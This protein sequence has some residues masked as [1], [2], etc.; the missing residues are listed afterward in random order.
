MG[1]A[2]KRQL[3]GLLIV[4]H[5]GVGAC[6]SV[7]RTPGARAVYV[8]NLS[9]EVLGPLIAYAKTEADCRTLHTVVSVVGKINSDDKTL[10]AKP[11]SECYVAILAAGGQLWA[12][13]VPGSWGMAAWG[14]ELC[15][16]ILTGRFWGLEP[17]PATRCFQATLTPVGK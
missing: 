5:V 16:A 10:Q 4:V 11:L 2:S 15:E 8:F 14:S 13:E 17:Q 12:G 3:A 7:P 9:H 6:A 1:L